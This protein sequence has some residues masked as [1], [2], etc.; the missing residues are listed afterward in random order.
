[1]RPL[2]GILVALAALSAP[3]VSQAAPP[4]LLLDQQQPVIDSSQA[5]AIGGDS[6]QMLAQV[7]TAGLSGRLTEI[8]LPIGCASGRLVLEI[9]GVDPAGLPNGIVLKRRSFVASRL[10]EVLPPVFQQFR[11]GRSLSIAAGDRF[12]IAVSNPTGSCGLSPGPVGSS[13]AGGEAFFDARP[14]TPGIWL[15]LVLSGETDPRDLAF[16]TYMIVRP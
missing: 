14:N 16:Q 2:L 12:A 8:W 3:G 11:L 1:M 7:V 6:E 9:Q 4:S 5:L 15:P 10:P 13:Y